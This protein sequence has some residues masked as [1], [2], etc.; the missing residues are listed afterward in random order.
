MTKSKSSIQT[1]AA[2]GESVL[3]LARRETD[4]GRSQLRDLAPEQ[5]A[6]AVQQL[7]PLQRLEF[8]ELA[9]RLD[10]IVPHL[11]ETE[12]TSTIRTIG[13]EEAGWLV[14]FASPEQRVAAVDL[15]CWKDNRFS[16]SRF[17]EWVDAMIEAGPEVLAAS[18]YEV[19]AVVWVLAM[20]SMA[21]FSIL[22]DENGSD[23][24]CVTDDGVVYFDPYTAEC[25]DRIREILNTARIYAP[26]QYWN[27]V[28][29]AI[30][31][32]PHESREFADRWHRGRLN[33]LGFPD[34]DHAMDAYSPLRADEAP[35]VDLAPSAPSSETS[36]ALEPAM[37]VP[38]QL[39]GTLLGLALSELSSTRG[40]EMLGY[41]LAV[42]NTLAVADELP[43]ADPESVESSF[44][45]AIRGIERGL[46]ELS[47]NRNQAPSAVLETT[48]PLDL[49]RVGATLDPSLRPS[50]SPA[51]LAEDLGRQ[52]WDV[53]T[54][55]ISEA[56]RTLGRSGQPN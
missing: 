6:E 48:V 7:P 54:E 44:K 15:D 18:F 12:F 33:D 35:A 34:R 47:K 9:E 50:K 36:H 46:A 42:A 52:D 14:E 19:D 28:Y 22:S 5:I 38:M 51:D 25:E 43:L 27:L 40:G 30:L 41:I 29:G 2:D 31:E 26:S 55:V 4:E 1:V 45:K 3:E 17:F 56:D 13:I 20:K 53:E 23:G 37:Q 8:F 10:E 32:N 24:E 21:D 11:P 16:P 49:F 39:S